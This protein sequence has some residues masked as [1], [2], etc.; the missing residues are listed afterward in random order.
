MELICR[1][2]RRSKQLASE[3]RLPWTLSITIS[4]R[5][6]SSARSFSFSCL[7]QGH[8][9]DSFVSSRLKLDPLRFCGMSSCRVFACQVSTRKKDFLIDP[10]DIFEQLHMLN[11][12]HIFDSY[13]TRPCCYQNCTPGF[14]RSAHRESASRRGP[15]GS[16]KLVLVRMSSSVSTWPGSP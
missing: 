3:T 6:L 11:E 2:W 10:F 13:S 4:G 15:H 9:V 1:L 16:Q 8:F 14:F 12:A 7:S 5:V